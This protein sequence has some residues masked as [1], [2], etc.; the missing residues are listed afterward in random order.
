MSLSIAVIIKYYPPTPSLLCLI[1]RLHPGTST[2]W[3]LLHERCDR[4]P[5]L[6]QVPT[7][8]QTEHQPWGAS[9]RC[10]RVQLASPFQLQCWPWG[11]RAEARHRLV[12]PQFGRVGIRGGTKNGYSTGWPA[13]ANLLLFNCTT[14][15]LHSLTR[16][17]NSQIFPR[18]N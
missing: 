7:A 5:W 8:R 16:P 11:G 4:T 17:L 2:E 13:L 6:I 3:F 12:G 1:R 18:F 14:L 9:G 15:S 10:W